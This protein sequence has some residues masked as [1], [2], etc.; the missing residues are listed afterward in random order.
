MSYYKLYVKYRVLSC[1]TS[2]CLHVQQQQLFGSDQQKRPTP[3]DLYAC[4]Y[5]WFLPLLR[6]LESIGLYVFTISR[7][8]R[9][10]LTFNPPFVI[11]SISNIQQN[12]C[13]KH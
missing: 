13:A 7:R 1:E 9:V 12:W 10:T 11:I 8:R 2:A 6:D 5:P 3:V 4:K